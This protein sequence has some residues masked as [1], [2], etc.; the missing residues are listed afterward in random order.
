MIYGGGSAPI[1]LPKEMAY[2]KDEKKFYS[3][4]Y[5]P[6]YWAANKEYIKGVDV[7][8]PAT[9]NGLMYECYSGGISGATEPTFNT[10]ENGV[11]DDNSVTWKAKAYN[12]LLNTDDII[13]TSTWTGTNSETL[14]S[15]II[16][17]G[18]YTKVRLT[19]VLP[20]AK[21]ATLI[22]HVVVIRLNG[23][24]EEFDRTIIIPVSVL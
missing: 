19:G 11:T 1:K 9:P 16:V 3:L 21:T 22:N 5:R 6:V 7:V 13:T 10:K 20:D 17:D 23:D 4:S 2:D 14:D 8:I 24:I 12:L 15:D 18:I